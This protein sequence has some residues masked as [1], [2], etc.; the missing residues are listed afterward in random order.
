MTKVARISE[1]AVISARTESHPLAT[2]ALFS[3][4]GL[5]ISLSVLLLAKYVPGE[6]F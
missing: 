4:I 3:A 1:P 2:V 5:L 6:W